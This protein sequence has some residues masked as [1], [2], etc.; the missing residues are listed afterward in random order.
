MSLSVSIAAYNTPVLLDSIDVTERIQQRST[1]NFAV[2][3]DA[4]YALSQD[5]A[6]T[7]LADGVLLFSGFVE[8]IET[9]RLM[10]ATTRLHAVAAK[11]WRYV[12]DKRTY[13][14]PEYVGRLAGD[15]AVDLVENYLKAEGVTATY[16]TDHDFNAA[17]FGQ[18]TLTNVTAANGDLE[19]TPSGTTFTKSETLTADWTA[20]GAVNT[21]VDTVN[22]QVT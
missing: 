11:D 21:N 12:A 22:D 20:A 15:I 13:T 17:T 6:V 4:I 3:D 5:Q 2:R 18:G 19:L 14:G 9:D 16:A 7:V 1:A 8:T 10:P